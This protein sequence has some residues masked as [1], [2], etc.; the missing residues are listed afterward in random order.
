M[1][2]LAP[3]LRHRTDLWLITDDNMATEFKR[4]RDDWTSG[5]DRTQWSDEDRNWWAVF[6]EIR[7]EFR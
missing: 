2:D 3:E 4:V 1:P 7:R 6:S 5:T